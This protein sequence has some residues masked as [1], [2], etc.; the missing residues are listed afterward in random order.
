MRDTAILAGVRTPVGA[1][2]G[3]LKSLRPARLAEIVIREVVRRANLDPVRDVH[4]VI[5][6]QVLPRTDE[7]TMVARTA[8]L[9]AG[10]PETVR[11]NSVIRGCGSG[12]QAVVDGVRAI[13][14]GDSDCV[15]AGGAESMSGAPFLLKEMRF[16]KLMRHS[17]ASDALWEVLHDPI[18]G[19]IM[20][21]T[22][23]NVARKYGVS[24]E[25]QDRYA[26][27]S[28]RKAVEAANAGRLSE[29]IVPVPVP[30]KKGDTVLVDRDEGPRPGLTVEQLGKLKCA[31][32]KPE[33]G[34]TVT[35]GNACGMNDGASALALM[36]LEQAQSRGSPPMARIL[37]YAYTALDPN[38][39]GY[40]PV[41]AVREALRRA[42]LSLADL[43]YMELNEAFAAQTIPVIRDLGFPP[44]RVNVNGGA[45]A[46]GHAV[47]NS[48]ARLLVSLVHVLKQKNARRGVATMCIGGG[49][50][51]AMIVERAGA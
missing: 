26:A 13:A 47:G 15:I 28:H 1:L 11:A 35:P 21:V 31:F 2:G 10:L 23:E 20:G 49:Q 51:M 45:L 29:E 9:M 30:G 18:T 33:E 48:G 42:K 50:A 40:G 41:T 6:G 14:V 7:N 46:L 12:M 25:E 4:E 38:Y 17:E 27:E 5:F 3:Q 22:G 32:L 39:M 37:G 36:D 44:E 8:A 19:S 34:G 24:R 16:G 43:E